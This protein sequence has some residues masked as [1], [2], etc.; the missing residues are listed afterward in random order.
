MS[1]LSETP[2]FVVENVIAWNINM[3]A[4]NEHRDPT[5]SNR[6]RNSASALQ[7]HLIG[8]RSA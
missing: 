3:A 6:Q 8:R 7:N 4:W 1:K 2:R 5:A